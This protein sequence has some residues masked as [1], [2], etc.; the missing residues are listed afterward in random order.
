MEIGQD[1]LEKQ[2]KYMGKNL[3]FK[4]SKFKLQVSIKYDGQISQRKK[5]YKIDK[6][7]KGFLPEFPKRF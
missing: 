1:F 5:L 7:K 4:I 6:N 3:I 2:Y